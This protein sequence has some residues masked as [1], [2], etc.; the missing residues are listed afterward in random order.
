VC[1]SQHVQSTNLNNFFKPW[2]TKG[3]LKSIRIKNKLFYSGEKGKYKQYIN[4]ITMLT[5]LSKTNYYHNNIHKD[6]T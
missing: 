3:L 5:K 2:I 4:K 6:I 1:H